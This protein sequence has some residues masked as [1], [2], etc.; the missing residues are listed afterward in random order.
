MTDL[1]A[2]NLTF[3]VLSKGIA[4]KM[5]RNYGSLVFG[6][7]ALTWPAT[8]LAVTPA[9][10]GL[11]NRVLGVSFQAITGYRFEF[12]KATEKVMMF[13]DDLSSANDGVEIEATGAAPASQTIYWEAIG[14]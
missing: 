2:S 14:V 5:R 3:T 1:A 4:G 12:N 8:G 13:H 10:F 7:G 11:M 6:N 9:N